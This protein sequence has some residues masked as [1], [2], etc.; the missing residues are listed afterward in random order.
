MSKFPAFAAGAALMFLGNQAS[1]TVLTF[2][3]V[4]LPNVV[5]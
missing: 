2:D 5:A 4:T 1:A 3:D